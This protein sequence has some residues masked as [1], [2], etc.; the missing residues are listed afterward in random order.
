[1]GKRG[2]LI[3]VPV[4]DLK[5]RKAV[6]RG[7]TAGVRK[8]RD[9]DD[10]ADSAASSQGLQQGP[11]PRLAFGRRFACAVVHDLQARQSLAPGGVFLRGNR[12]SEISRDR[13]E[14][15]LGEQYQEGEDRRSVVG[16]PRRVV[17]F[18][19]GQREAGG[20]NHDDHHHEQE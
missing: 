2:G 20:T 14:G 12:Q 8:D 4:D 6:H 19:L 18:Q 7:L 15:E 9:V 17:A 13:S 10:E 5:M 3:F 16:R 1:M 11:I